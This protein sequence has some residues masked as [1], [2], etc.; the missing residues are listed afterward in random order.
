MK[1]LSFKT[2]EKF[3]AWLEKNHASCEGIWLRFY[4][5][6]SGKTYLNYAQALDQALCFGWIDGQV[7]S[8]DEI[9]WIHKFTPRRARSGWSQINVGHVARLTAAGLM[10]PSGLAA[11]A[12]A[13][14]DGR[15][16]RAYVSPRDATPPEDFMAELRK[17]PRA[18]AF[19]TTLN[20][21][22]IYAIVYRLHTAKKPETR[23]R[24]M[25]LMLAM[26]Q[27]GEVFHPAKAVKS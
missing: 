25:K 22:N 18:L 2:P 19:F 7:K 10:A 20:R 4:K 15:W 6:S 21:A 27:R 1:I 17:S 24:R 3:R 12:S 23:A 13:Q 11:V 5:K 26:L 9:S 14:K 16:A 8:H